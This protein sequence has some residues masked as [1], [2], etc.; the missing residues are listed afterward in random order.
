MTDKKFT[1][2]KKHMITHIFFDRDWTLSQQHYYSQAFDILCDML[3]CNAEDIL[4][5]IMTTSCNS[6]DDYANA[7]ATKLYYNPNII[8]EKLFLSWYRDAIFH[9]SSSLQAF[10]ESYDVLYELKSSWFILCLISDAL[11]EFKN[12]TIHETYF[13]LLDHCFFSCDLWMTKKDKNIYKK[14]EKILSINLWN[15]IMVWDKEHRD[16]LPALDAWCSNAILIQ[17]K[18]I[19]ETPMY[20]HCKKKLSYQHIIHDLSELKKYL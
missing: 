18:D 6:L 5:P 7:I 17:H 13:S 3:N 11:S 1:W 14:I 9:E 4:D 19:I 12:H 10:P 20:T 2:T 16:I 8:K 15:T